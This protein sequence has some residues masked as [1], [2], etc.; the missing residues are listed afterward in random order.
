MIWPLIGNIMLC[1]NVMQ[2]QRTHV[3]LYFFKVIA[4]KLKFTW[5]SL[6]KNTLVFSCFL[7][8]QHL[9]RYSADIFTCKIPYI[10]KHGSALDQ[11]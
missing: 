4:E 7:F 5:V 10:F 9:S 3:S 11:S 8:L 6:Q 1:H 2:V